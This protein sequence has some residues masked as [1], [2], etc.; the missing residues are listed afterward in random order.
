MTKATRTTFYCRL[1][2]ED[3]V[4][5]IATSIQVIIPPGLTREQAF[6]YAAG[7]IGGELRRYAVQE[8]MG[9]SLIDPGTKWNEIV[10]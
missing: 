3:G 1:L 6:D 5:Q 7:R 2:A 4:T 8:A 9:L 10:T